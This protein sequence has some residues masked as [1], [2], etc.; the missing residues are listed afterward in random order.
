MITHS[1]FAKATVKDL[2]RPRLAP[3]MFMIVPSHFCLLL[4]GLSHACYAVHKQNANPIIGPKRLS[5][6]PKSTPARDPKQLLYEVI[7]L[8]LCGCDHLGKLT[9]LS[10]I[11]QAHLTQINRL[12][13]L[14]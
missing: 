6:E 12:S 4:G 10:S 7:W 13:L 8:S 3:S 1:T 11:A 5:T 2:G 9:Q 14:D